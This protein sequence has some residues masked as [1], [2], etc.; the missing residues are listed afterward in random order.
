MGRGASQMLLIACKWKV[1]GSEVGWGPCHWRWRGGVAIRGPGSQRERDISCVYIYISYVYIYGNYIYIYIICV[2]IYI[3]ISV[4]MC[5]CVYVYMCICTY[6]HMCIYVYM[7]ICV[8]V[9]MC[10]CV[11][12]YIYTYGK[13]LGFARN[14]NHDRQRII[15]I[16]KPLSK[17]FNECR[18]LFNG[19]GRIKP[20]LRIFNEC[21][22]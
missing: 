21:R 1:W 8:Y 14:R 9:C 13:C 16:I 20:S 7:C 11:Y 15:I 12:V 2:Y 3:Y 18:S 10:I 17:V 22:S 19:G 6:V 4:Y 5:I